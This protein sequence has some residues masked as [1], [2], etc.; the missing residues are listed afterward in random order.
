[1]GW[2]A[3]TELSFPIGIWAEADNAADDAPYGAKVLDAAAYGRLVPDAELGSLTARVHVSRGG[4]L[5]PFGDNTGGMSERKVGSWSRSS[6]TAP[7]FFGSKMV[8]QKGG[9]TNIGIVPATNISGSV[10][11]S[12]GN[13]REAPK[14]APTNSGTG[15]RDFEMGHVAD[16]PQMPLLTVRRLPRAGVRALAAPQT[17]QR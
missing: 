17:A 4:Q 2:K 10:P 16:Y 15:F 9:Q 12:C 5:A 7:T 1:L 14:G 3:E 11:T 8:G 13:K 6:A